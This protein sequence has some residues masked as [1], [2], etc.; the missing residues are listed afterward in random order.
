MR[1]AFVMAAFGAALAVPAA[2]A[3]GHGHGHGHDKDEWWDGDCH[4]VRKWKHGE[5][6]EKRTCHEHR[7]QAVYVVPAR[8]AVIV[9][10]QPVMV[11]P[12][13]P[14]QPAMAVVYP[15]WIVQQRGQYVYHPEYRPVMATGDARRCNSANVGRVLGGIVGGVLGNQ[16]GSGN[17]RTAATVGGAVA[18]VLVGGEVGRRI[19]AGN[20][21]CVGEV[22][23][24]A[25]VG[26][27]VQWVESR[28]TYVVTPGRVT[29]RHGAH[30]RP[31]TLDM[32]VGAGWQRTEGV[33][34]RRPG[35][36]WVAA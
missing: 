3:D 6:E 16:I 22:L 13:P 12:P 30:C 19:D 15:P 35:G 23:E 14:P 21:A 24:V 8:P 31:Y 1:K 9:Q 34:C 36:V 32:Q 2:F 28:T 4:V 26:R 27:R 5:V 33:A 7:P 10:P 29:E 25:P 11:A 18:G 17:G 20:Q